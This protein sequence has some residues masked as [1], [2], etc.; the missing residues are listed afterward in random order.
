MSP[1]RDESGFMMVAML[2]GMAILA[3]WMT[4]AVP[5]WRQQTQRSKEEQLIFIGEQYARAIALFQDQN[6]GALP[7]DIDTLI[8]Q[9]FLRKKWKDPITGD[10]FSTVGIGVVSYAPKSP[11]E[12]AKYG[13]S[14][15]ANQ[16]TA[17]VNVTSQQPGI[18][19]VRSRSC[20]TSI[21][22]Y[23]Q[24]QQHNLWQF[25]AQL[26]RQIVAQ[27]APPMLGAEGGQPG[28]AGE[29][30]RG[31]QPGR[32]GDP[33]RGGP[34]VG[35]PGRGGGGPGVGAPGR[36]GGPPAPPPGRGGGR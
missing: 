4:A 5:A 27:T 20:R 17:P 23:Q 12:A 28:R 35:A 13:C 14:F 9:R 36:G 31:G 24:Q 30:G 21:K 6:R 22:V 18:T 2:I 26:Y 34:G 16:V 32:G 15:N 33:G 3:I 29:P 8:S 11:Q 25:D 10:D 7:Q 1:R 19:G